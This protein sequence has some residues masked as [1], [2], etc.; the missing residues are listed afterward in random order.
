ML[1]VIIT[2]HDQQIIVDFEKA[3]KYRTLPKYR[4]AFVGDGECNLIR[5]F[6][7]VVVI[8][9]LEHNIEH[10]KNLVDFTAWYA[11][12]RNNVT[13]SDYVA[14]L[15]YDTAITPDFYAKTSELIAKNT[16]KIIGYQ[17]WSMLD[18][19][20]I[21]NN[22]GYAPLAEALAAAYGMNLRSLVDDYI[23]LNNDRSWPS[24]NNL[25]LSMS[26][27]KNF[28]DWFSPMID[29]LG[30]HTYS[31]HSVERSIK[32]YGI[33]AGVAIMYAPELA[34]HYQLNSHGTQGFAVDFSNEIVKV[35]YNKLPKT[36]K[37][38]IINTIRRFIAG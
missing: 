18:E 30:P 7:N 3:Q 35:A 23:A 22:V 37:N 13:Q 19:N 32:I 25:A 9:E 15:Q 2:V 8:R 27:L 11:I 20:F 12:S 4:Y 17:E 26:R 24:S 14:L 38:I 28:V 34:H 33:I 1:D 6:T 5:N 10:Y 21:D 16:G 31:G 36:K 29:L